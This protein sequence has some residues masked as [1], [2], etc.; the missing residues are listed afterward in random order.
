MSAFLRYQIARSLW[1][2][3]LQIQGVAVSWQI[4]ARSGDPLDLGWVGLAQF[5]PVMLLW[6]LTGMAADRFDRRWITAICAAGHMIVALALSAGPHPVPLTLGLLCFGATARAFSA[7]AQQAL[8]PMLVT[9]AQFPR[10][11]ALNSSIFQ[12]GA[13][14]GPALGGLLYSAIGPEHTY[15]ISAAMLAGAAILLPT[16]PG[17]AVPAAQSGA[18]ESPWARVS[19]GLR[20]VWARPALLGAIGLDMV[21]VLLGGAVALLPIFA[22]DILS[23]GPEL[24]GMLR[25]A[26]AVGAVLTALALATWPIRRHAGPLLL[27]AV[28][29]FGAATVV[30]GLS[31]SVP[32]SLAAL[33]CLGAA[34]EVSVVIR[35]TVVQLNTPDALRGRVS[36][37][38]FLFISVSNEVGQF[39]SGLTASWWGPVRAAL[40]GGIGSVISALLF[41]LFFPELRRLDRLDREQPRGQ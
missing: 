11:V 36:A 17:R 39:E 35:Q 21:A 29:V 28:A 10:A 7:P 14:L 4:Y 5:L 31:R 27:G 25:G 32:L 40:F 37:V 12:L 18:A 38:N 3:A 16:L 2:F 24:L 26:P 15:R 8:L 1:I 13:T 19:A 30:F 23:G 34:D 20:F 41:G 6:P 33:A 9:P 22:Q